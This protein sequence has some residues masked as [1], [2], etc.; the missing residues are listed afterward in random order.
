MSSGLPMAQAL[1]CSGCDAEVEP[2]G[3]NVAVGI[4]SCQRCGK[5]MDLAAPRGPQ[6]GAPAPAAPAPKP[7]PAPVAL[8]APRPRAEPPALRSRVPMPEGVT[9]EEGPGG[10]EVTYRSSLGA[11][12]TTVGGLGLVGAYL[13]VRGYLDGALASVGFQLA[14][15]VFLLVAGYAAAGYLVNR[16]RVRAKGRALDVEVG[17]LP[18]PGSLRVPRGEVR[19][20]FAEARP[21]PNRDG[22]LR[23]CSFVLSAVVGPESRRVELVTGLESK[24]QAL[25][26]EQVL[27]RALGIHPARVGGEID[28]AD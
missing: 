2:R 25:W 23:A 9:A 18:W 20:L 14:A 27:E 19:Q 8:A 11:R 15:A 7:E 17:P 21:I 13:G 22:T 10:L 12:L 16:V 1:R 4:A 28:D 5:V 26:L 24:Q 6:V 3:V